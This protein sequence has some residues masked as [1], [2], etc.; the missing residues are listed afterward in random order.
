MQPR[1]C[2]P[3][4]I[5]FVYLDAIDKRLLTAGSL[6]PD[7]PDAIRDE[8]ADYDPQ[9]YNRH[10]LGPVRLREALACSL[11]VPAVFTLSRL[12]ARAAYYR[13]HKWGFDDRRGGADYGAG[14][15]WGNAETP[16]VGRPAR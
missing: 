8:Y 11:N 1:S 15:V 12:G 6:L 7:T 5:P 10:Y 14:C 3:T 2:A 16:L 9:N 4:L 13:V